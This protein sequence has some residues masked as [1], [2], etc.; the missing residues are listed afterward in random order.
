LDMKIPKEKEEI[1]KYAE[2]DANDVYKY[3]FK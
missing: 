3:F 2:E 1:L